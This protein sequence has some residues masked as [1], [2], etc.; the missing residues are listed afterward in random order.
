MVRCRT[1]GLRRNRMEFWIC[2]PGCHQRATC[3]FNAYLSDNLY[4]GRQITIRQ[5]LDQT[6]GI[7]NPIPLRWVYL[8]EEDASFDEALALAEVLRVNF[9]L[10]FA[11]G[12]K[13]A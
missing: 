3:P 10:A 13:F 2:A 9:K 4:D 11:P 5:L 8:T 7:P 12:H 1:R 6:S